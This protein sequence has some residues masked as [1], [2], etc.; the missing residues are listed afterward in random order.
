MTKID[1]RWEAET[2]IYAA[3][4]QALK[5]SYIECRIDNTSESDCFGI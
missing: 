3:N 4:V 1:L 2:V 5:S